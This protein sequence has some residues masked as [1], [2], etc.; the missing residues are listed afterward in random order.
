MDNM[1]CTQV[2][3]G[4]PA[5]HILHEHCTLC[6][7]VTNICSSEIVASECLATKEWYCKTS[8][9]M[10]L[11]YITCSI[12]TLQIDTRVYMMCTCYYVWEE[13]LCFPNELLGSSECS[14]GGSI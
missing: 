10:L 4:P 3:P 14:G 7:I 11:H 12:R 8:I 2:G 6:V 1:Y 9:Y 13:Q 5:S